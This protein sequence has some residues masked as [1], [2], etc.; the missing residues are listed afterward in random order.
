M[1][2]PL[3]LKL[4]YADIGPGLVAGGE[5]EPQLFKPFPDDRIEYAQLQR[6]SHS[7]N[8][9]DVGRCSFLLWN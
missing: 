7:Q 3:F 2:L 6:P 1:Y 4:I 8:I 9:Y 5:N